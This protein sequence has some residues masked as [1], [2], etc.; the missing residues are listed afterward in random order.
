ML[1]Y[2]Q[3]GRQIKLYDISAKKHMLVYLMPDSIL[4]LHVR[5]S[6]LRACDR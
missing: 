1:A 2:V 3:S 5:Q 6:K 4:A